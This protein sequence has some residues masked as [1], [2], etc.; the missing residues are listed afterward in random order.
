M[1]A[2]K[3]TAAAMRND[4][5]ALAFR[6]GNAPPRPLRV[7]TVQDVAEAALPEILR[8]FSLERPEVEL[9]LRVDRSA[10]LVEAVHAGELDL[11]IAVRRDDA[12]ARGTLAETPMAWIG[13]DTMSREPPPF[14]E[15]VRLALFEAPCSFRSAALD[16]LSSSGR[17][18]QISFTS[19]SL[20]GLRSAVVAGLGV[21][22]RTP[23][24]LGPGHADVGEALGLP[25]LPT[26]A[27]A[28]Y[29]GAGAF[30]SPVREDFAELCRRTL[31]PNRTGATG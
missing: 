24:L 6:P 27:F 12:L 7:G 3:L 31:Q 17:S 8:R 26:V 11:A 22:V 9:V 18:H 21:T 29:A 25:P 23:Y 10:R 28:L 20:S 14:G 30:P 5:A 19:P 13:R 1:S 16:A 15:P 4:E 2:S